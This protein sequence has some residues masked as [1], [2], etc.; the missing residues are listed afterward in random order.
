MSDVGVLERRFREHY[1]TRPEII[2]RAPGRVEVIGGH[3]DYNDGFVLP[4]AID[5]QCLIL[6]SRRTDRTVRVYSEL[7]GEGCAFELSAALTSGEPRWESW[8]RK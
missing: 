7:F 5:R 6:A 8:T 3:T 1:G 4:M 2:V